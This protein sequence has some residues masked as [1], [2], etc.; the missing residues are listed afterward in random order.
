VNSILLAGRD[1]PDVGGVGEMAAEQI[2][3]A[4]SRGGAEKRYEYT[5]PNEDV[6]LAA[7]GRHGVLVAIADGHWGARAA[8]VAVAHLR[9]AHAENWLEAES[10]SL[11]SWYQDVLH[12]LVAANEAILAAHVPPDEKPRTTLSFAFARPKEDLLVLAS[13]G[14]SHL[15]VAGATQVAEA[16]P[17][18][19]K[20]HFLGNAK[21][22]AS[23]LAKEVRIDVR[24]LGDSRALFA[25]TDGISEHGIGVADPREA[26]RS[27]VASADAAA[28]PARASV[29]ARAL[30]DSVLT[31][32][33]ANDAGDN[34]AVAVAWLER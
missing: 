12:A 26:V 5:D 14:D 18:P 31:A 10:R 34:I 9:D 24:P 11:E 3:V 29:A 21:R 1:Y 23:Q 13:A 7:T 22:K 30:L 27:A 15:F 19:R 2:A 4:L 28:K 20:Y 17:C 8:E 16:L 6:A 32:H 33:V 25:V